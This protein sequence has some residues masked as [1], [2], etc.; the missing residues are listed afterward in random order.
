MKN[1][2]NTDFCIGC[3]K[4]TEYV[5]KEEYRT[6]TVKDKQYTYKTIIAYCSECGEEMSVPGLIDKDMEIF[7]A[8]YRM[9]EGL[10][11]IP[12]IKRLMDLYNLGKAPLAFAL[13]FGEVTI[14]RYLE[15]QLPSKRY[16]DLMREALFNPDFMLENLNDNRRRVGEVAYHKAAAAIAEI[17]ERQAG[18]PKIHDVIWYLFDKLTEVTPLA[19]QKLLY[20]A[21]GIHLSMYGTAFFEDNCEAWVNG[22]VYA[23]V[24]LMYKDFGFNPL[25]EEHVLICR[26]REGGL[27]DSEKQILDLL[28]STFGKLS[29]TMLEEMVKNEEPWL[30]ARNGVE[31]IEYA[32]NTISKES[33][34]EFFATV[35]K[36]FNLGEK[37][38]V[39]AFLRER[40][41]L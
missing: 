12:E 36:V 41:G 37:E 23:D 33:M 20:Y 6:R 40:T 31:T 15:G 4:E 17:K 8:Y 21:Q 11:S 18:T 26:S 7:D 30:R 39:T 1:A 35:H 32:Q 3:R 13:G 16:S 9:T 19:L 10:I 14:A 28:V 27:K 25:S 29:G 5:V 2:K 22:P 34:T 38:G 24:Y